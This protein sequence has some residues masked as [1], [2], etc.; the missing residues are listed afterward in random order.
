MPPI[1]IIDGNNLIHAKYIVE[2]DNISFQTMEGT[3]E[4]LTRWADAEN[5]F[6]E[7]CVDPYP[8]E[9][10]TQGN[11]RLMVEDRKAD[12]LV[13]ER[14]LYHAYNGQPCV[15]VTTDE[16]LQDTIRDLG[17]DYITSQDFAWRP[18]PFGFMSLP[19]IS[20]VP[21]RLPVDPAATL[22]TIQEQVPIKIKKHRNSKQKV[23]G[24]PRKTVETKSM[25]ADASV[26]LRPESMLE[27]TSASMEN[28]RDPMIELSIGSTFEDEFVLNVENWPLQKGV[29]F[30]LESACSVHQRELTAIIGN[31]ATVTSKDL[32]SAL[33][34]FINLCRDEPDFI[35]RGGSLMD[36]VRLALIK[37][38]PNPLTLAQIEQLM[39]RKTSGMQ[40]KIN[41][42]S[43]L[44]LVKT[45][46]Q[47]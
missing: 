46:S 5:R 23:D 22:H 3:I 18:G 14:A 45:S 31:V 42:Y 41:N 26:A 1:V 25:E 9:P 8:I 30:I 33:E 27:S 47:N 16:D 39:N 21:V 38:Y 32:I 11:L 34:L 4:K 28:L 35:S 13:E 2:N 43:P 36:Q 37:E 20:K 10:R 40:K 44:W 19:P 24:N 7:L 12:D 6:V 29:R 15:V 17:I